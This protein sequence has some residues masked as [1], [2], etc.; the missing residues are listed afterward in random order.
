[1]GYPKPFKRKGFSSFFF[2]YEDPLTGKRKLKSTGSSKLGESREFV[3]RFMDRLT[4]V[5]TVTFREYATKFFSPETNPRYIRYKMAGK[6]YSI[7]HIKTIKTE[8]TKYVFPEKF[9]DKPFSE[10]TRGDV[11]DLMAL[12]VKKYPEHPATIN[13]VAKIIS[14]IFSEAYYRED[15][16]YNPAMRLSDIDYEK[17]QRGTFSNEEIRRIFQHPDEWT[18]RMAYDIFLFAAYTGRRCGEVLGLQWEQIKDG[19]CHIDRAYNRGTKGMAVP[20][21]DKKVTIPL[22]KTLL[23]RL[24]ERTASP[25]VF[26]KADG[27][28]IKPDT[29]NKYF[30]KEMDRMG[31]DRKARQL[32]PHSFRH[33]LNTNLIIALGG[34]ELF[35][36]KYI[37]WTD[38]DKDTQAAYTHIKPEHLKFIADKIDEI[39][40]LDL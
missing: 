16:K 27:T 7:S 2:N 1:M 39:Y 28:P 30:R 18:N 15:L 4:P 10:I 38:R 36:K 22:C 9:S 34:H 33:S 40:C 6:Q 13:K 11:L 32:V 37:G 17:V 14:S 19:C 31:F 23:D 12:L 24:P 8:I 35:V 3:Q 25:Y 20:K 5:G 26:V 29:W 21:W